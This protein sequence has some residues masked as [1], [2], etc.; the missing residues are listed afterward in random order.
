MCTGLR[1]PIGP[2]IATIELC[3]QHQKPMVTRIQVTGKLGDL[4]SQL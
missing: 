2:P 1:R 3:N 4:R